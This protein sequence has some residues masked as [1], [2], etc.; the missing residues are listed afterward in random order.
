MTKKL[1][2]AWTLFI[3]FALPTLA[4]AEGE[5]FNP[6]NWAGWLMFLLALGLPIGVGIWLRNRDSY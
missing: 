3:L 4:F 1:T 6:P 2:T 5:S